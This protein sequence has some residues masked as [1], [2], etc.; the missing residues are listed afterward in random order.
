M[1]VARFRKSGVPQFTA[2]HLSV[3]NN[4]STLV[5]C[6]SDEGSEPEFAYLNVADVR[7]LV[8]YLNKVLPEPTDNQ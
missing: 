8:E 2:D 7:Q 1:S 3:R 4:G 6:T 5:F